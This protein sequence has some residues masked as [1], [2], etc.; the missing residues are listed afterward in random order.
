M[1][2]ALTARAVAAELNDRIVGGRV[3]AVLSLD[4]LTIGF[5]IYA[6]RARHYL[7]VSAD[8]ARSRAHLVPEKLRG[9][10]E[11]PGP[12]FLLLRK[13]AD[14]AFV[15]RVEAVPYERILHIEF[16]HA[17]QGVAT[18]VA[19][20]MGRLSN[21]ILLDAGGV[22]IDAIK[23]VTPAMSRARIVQPRVRYLPPPP[24][25]KADPLELTPEQLARFL[26]DALSEPVW[27]VLVRTVRGTSP[28]L[29]REL[30][31]RAAGNADAV[32]DISLASSLHTEVVNVWRAPPRPTLAFEADE[33]TAVAAFALTHFRQAKHLDSMSEALEQF[34]GEVESYQVVKEPLRRELEAARA[35][36]ERKREA[37]RRQ[38]IPHA[39]VERLKTSGELILAYTADIAPGQTSLVAEMVEGQPLH[40]KLDP[41]LTPVENAQKYFSEYRRAKEAAAVVPERLEEVE[42]DLAFADQVLE[43]LETAETRPEI[44]AAVGEAMEAGLMGKGRRKGAPPPALSEPRVY[45]SPDGLQV[46]VGRNARQNE[47]ITF[48]RAEAEDLWLHARGVAGAHVVILANGRDVG[49]STLEF[50]ASLAAFYSK[51]RAQKWVDVAV[52]PRKNVRRVSGRAARPGLVTVR[53]ERTTRVRPAEPH[54]RP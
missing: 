47:T 34:F 13:Y 31:F 23:R 3:Q 29:A 54:N 17:Q 35:R 5:E 2:D 50:A 44:D 39:Q 51:A 24:Q 38:L 28:L 46:L 26:G 9:S 45:V 21:L 22:V 7:L 14:G 42:A 36:F 20:I 1:F 32:T 37:L 33:P 16:D 53:G 48:E 8:P 11:T 18:L 27:Q 6:Q 43:D 52:A 4:D 12:F 40:I 30:A 10:L 41:G 19:E 15:N 49:E 25:E